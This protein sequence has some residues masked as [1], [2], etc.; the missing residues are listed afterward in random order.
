[1]SKLSCDVIQDLLPLYHDDVCSEESSQLVE[2]H[3]QTC[4]QCRKELEQMDFTISIPEE[5]DE[6]KAAAAAARAWTRN[7]KKAFGLGLA[8]ALL[9]VFF[10]GGSFLWKHISETS[11]RDDIE[12]LADQWEIGKLHVDEV[13]EKGEHLILLAYD[14]E[15]K[16]YMV[17][18]ERD[19]IFSE[20]WKIMGGLGNMRLGRIASWNYKTPEGD[21]ILIC[22]GM[23]ISS[24]IWGYTFTNN[25]VTYTCQVEDGKVLDLFYIPDT[26]DSDTMVQEIFVEDIEEEQE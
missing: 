13:V 24:R 16:R 7:R 11:R 3:L 20:R 22:Y 14:D 10:A 21:T 1:M 2:E 12:G 4:E 8:L 6:M 23:N 25:G 26:Y 17:A 18:Y 9:L 5:K 15:G 19:T